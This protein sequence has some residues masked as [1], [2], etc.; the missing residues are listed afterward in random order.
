LTRIIV[1]QVIV[2]RAAVTSPE[3]HASNPSFLSPATVRRANWQRREPHGPLDVPAP[4]YARHQANR[5]GNVQSTRVG[6]KGEYESFCPTAGRNLHGLLRRRGDK[7]ATTA[8]RC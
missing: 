4:R 2:C 6:T 5:N 8:V 1:A 3:I 7:T